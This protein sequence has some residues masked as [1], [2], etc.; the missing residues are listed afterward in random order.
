[1]RAVVQRVSRA[2]VVTAGQVAGAIAEGLCV[3]VAA[4]SGDT[5]EDARFIAHKV[6]SLRI[7]PD[8]QGR[9]NRDVRESGGRVL[10]ISQF[11]LA[12]DTTSGTRPSFSAAL[13]PA[14]AEELLQVLATH[15]A[16][17]GLS[18]ATGVFGA[19]M[20]VELTNDGPVTIYLDSRDKRHK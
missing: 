15:L 18:A 5:E 19:K 8:E 13:A 16:N 7:F 3:L 17:E 2:R 14:E 20:Q 12:A 6:A 4:L 9:M 1:V 10:L 11:T